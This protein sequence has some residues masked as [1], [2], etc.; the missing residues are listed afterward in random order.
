[1]DIVHS[2]EF[3]N[4]IVNVILDNCHATGKERK[5][6]AQVV[7]AN[8][9]NFRLAFTSSRENPTENYQ[10]LEFLGDSIIFACVTW[11]LYRRFP[12]LQECKYLCV[13]TRLKGNVV[14]TKMLADAAQKLGFKKYLNTNVTENFKVDAFLEDVFEA[15]IGAV[16]LSFDN[17]YGIPGVG[18]NIC[19][20]IIDNIFKQQN[21]D[22]SFEATFDSKSALKEIL[23]ANPNLG[24]LEYIQDTP[25]TTKILLNGVVI[26]M[27][28]GQSK[29]IQH[30]LAAKEALTF[31]KEN[32]DIEPRRG[33][34]SDLV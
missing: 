27:G 22:L 10:M 29:K 6:I 19:Y 25:K 34:F 16:N 8:I 2:H 31:L 32:Y 18:Y 12:Q 1:M 5:E 3:R 30:Q 7:D 28:E 20:R 9:N 11:H 14:S 15:F 13:I 21:I 26:G 17:T 23:D 24:K 33:R 4:F